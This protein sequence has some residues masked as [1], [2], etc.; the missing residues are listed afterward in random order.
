LGSSQ[1]C[2]Y[3]IIS[4]HFICP[5]IH[6]VLKRAL[7][8]C[9]S[10][11]RSIQSIPPH[12]ISLRSIWIR[13][14]SSVM[15]HRVQLVWCTRRHIPE[16]GILHSHRCENLKSYILILSTHQR[17]G[18]PS[19]FPT[20]ISYAFLFSPVRTTSPVHLILLHL[21]ILIIFG[22]EYKLWSSSLCSFLQSPITSSIFGPH[23]LLN[24]KFSNTISLCSNLN[25]RD[26][27]Q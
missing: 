19:G 2:I 4:Q 12:F 8:W 6:A 11:T 25:I 5:K 18:L 7:H 1:F 10:W 16:H 14:P 3:S 23:I 26:Q 20:N 24:T 17:L 13:M 9:L 21:I 27:L 15:W 22:N